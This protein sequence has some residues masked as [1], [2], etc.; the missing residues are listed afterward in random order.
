VCQGFYLESVEKRVN[1]KYPPVH[2][3]HVRPV[4]LLCMTPSTPTPTRPLQ[5]GGS[6]D[7]AVFCPLQWAN[8]CKK[9]NF[10]RLGAGLEVWENPKN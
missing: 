5:G 10:P 4:C 6:K 8:N 2:R 1:E 9:R 3:V 7:F